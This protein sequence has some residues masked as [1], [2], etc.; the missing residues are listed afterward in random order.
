MGST[1][2]PIST[3]KGLL[4]SPY[5]LTLAIAQSTIKAIFD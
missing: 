2:L 3:G 1:L 5:A 4:K